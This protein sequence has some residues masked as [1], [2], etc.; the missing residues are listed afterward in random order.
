LLTFSSLDNY[1]LLGGSMPRSQ[2]QSIDH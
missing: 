1:L 2:T